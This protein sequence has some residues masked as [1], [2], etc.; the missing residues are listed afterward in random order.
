LLVP[1]G[2]LVPVAE[3]SGAYTNKP[4]ADLS[5]PLV[6]FGFAIGATE[7]VPEPSTIIM[8]V[9]GALCLVGARLRRK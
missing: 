2:T 6:N 1:D 8:I 4:A 7:P 3:L 9:L 5:L